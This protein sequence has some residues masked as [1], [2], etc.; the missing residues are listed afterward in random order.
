M[1]EIIPLTGGAANAHQTFF[2]QLGDNFTEFR[3]NYIT[4]TKEWA[5]DVYVE[6]RPVMMG[7]M[8]KPDAPIS[9]TYGDPI[10]RFVFVGKEPTLD[11]LGVD[12]YLGWYE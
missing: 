5:M 1:R 10:G 2:L 8:L 7:V 11:N 3:V 6:G 4:L 9:I 12:N